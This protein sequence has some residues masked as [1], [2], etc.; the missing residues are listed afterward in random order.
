MT[1]TVK[2][3]G[4]I[5]KRASQS[6]QTLAWDIFHKIY[7]M[8]SVI[9]NKEETNEAFLITIMTYHKDMNKV[10]KTT[11]NSHDNH[12]NGFTSQLRTIVPPDLHQIQPW[13][14]QVWNC[15]EIGFDPKSKWHKV[16]C[17]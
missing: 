6:G 7:H 13:A 8:Y 4:L 16:V 5:H 12:Q 14:T 3:Y 1:A 9:K 11:V 15:D 10:S 2:F 17:T